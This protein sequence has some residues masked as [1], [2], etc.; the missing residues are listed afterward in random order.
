MSS[1]DIKREFLS[2][3]EWN[4]NFWLE[5]DDNPARLAA[6]DERIERAASYML[7]LA[8]ECPFDYED[9][10]RIISGEY[11]ISEDTVSDLFDS[12]EIEISNRQL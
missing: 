10:L 8:N 5:H 2:L 4:S 7:G 3:M 11:G 12:I 9:L 6:R 1:S